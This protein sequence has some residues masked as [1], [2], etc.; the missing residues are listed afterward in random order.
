MDLVGLYRKLINA[1]RAMPCDDRVPYA[2]EQRVMARLAGLKVL[3]AWE[4][5]GRALSR[6][7]L[8]CVIFM[9]VLAIGSSFLPAASQVPLPQD[10]QRTLFAAVDNS[11]DLNGEAK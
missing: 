11:A 4:L 2:F 10:V 9:L 8:V 5:W 1:A 6:A 3:D 7:A